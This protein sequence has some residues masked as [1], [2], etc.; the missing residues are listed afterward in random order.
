[1]DDQWTQGV[2]AA[3]IRASWARVGKDAGTR[4]DFGILASSAEGIDV[5]EFYAAYVAGLPSPDMDMTLPSAPPWVTFGV[6]AAASGPLV[7]VGVQHRWKGVDQASR[8]IWP[9]DFFICRYTDLA[10]HGVS[11][12]DLYGAIAR[13]DLERHDPSQV[14]LNIQPMR[15]EQLSFRNSDAESAAVIS[16]E[17]AAAIAAA[18]LD[19]P[20]AVTG[21]AGLEL[22]DRLRLLDAVAAL[23]PYGYRAGLSA[24]TA[25]SS[26]ILPLMRLV[27]TEF[28]SDGQHV[29]DLRRYAGPRAAAG[30]AYFRML[31]EKYENSGADRKY[32]NSGA[33]KIVRY[34]WQERHPET[35]S[36]NGRT[37][38]ALEILHRLDWE[39]D[40]IRRI[41]NAKVIEWGLAHEFFGQTEDFV[42]RWWPQLSEKHTLLVKSALESTRPETALLLVKHWYTIISA[43]IGLVNERLDQGDVEFAARSLAIAGSAHQ[44]DQAVV[45]ADGLLSRLIVPGSDGLVDLPWARRV[46]PR[47]ELLARHDVSKLGG[48]RETREFLRLHGPADGPAQI[49]QA[50]LLRQLATDKA[51]AKNWA[52][53]LC[54]SDRSDKNAAQRRSEWMTALDFSVHGS[55]DAASA[56]SACNTVSRTPGWTVPVVEL[57]RLF[58]NEAPV[59]TALVDEFLRQALAD[60]ADSG[61]GPVRQAVGNAI[62][63][64]FRPDPRHPEQHGVV[65]VPEG[66]LARV[67]AARLLLDL[68]PVDFPSRPDLTDFGQY[69]QGMNE[70]L[71]PLASYQR[72]RDEQL[73]ASLQANVIWADPSEPRPLSWGAIQLIKAWSHDQL[74]ARAL[75]EHINKSERDAVVA[76]LW[77]FQQLAPGEWDLLGESVPRLRKYGTRGHL[78]MAVQRAIENPDAAL[79]RVTDDST[80]NGQ[81]KV[82][83]LASDLE[84]AIFRAWLSEPKMEESLYIIQG[85]RGQDGRPYAG[86][87]LM[88]RVTPLRF[89]QVLSEIQSLIRNYRKA[90]PGETAVYSPGQLQA[91]KAAQAK[92]ADL[93]WWRC[94][95]LIGWGNVLGEDYGRLF[96]QMAEIRAQDGAEVYRRVVILLGA[97]RLRRRHAELL[98]ECTGMTIAELQKTQKRNRDY[99]AETEEALP[100]PA[101]R[102]A[103]GSGQPAGGPGETVAVPKRRRL[104]AGIS[105]IRRR[106]GRS[107]RRQDKESRQD[108]E[109]RQ[110]QESK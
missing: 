38:A 39:N 63:A 79:D 23:L 46:G 13:V 19:G 76:T 64:P 89:W 11:Y 97:K 80:E 59:L 68:P 57:S 32:E 47:I 108:Q 82:S 9:R 92:V 91:L 24:S 61:H 62:S 58:G 67:D 78:V 4:E 33:E 100:L 110:S 26:G 103:S 102:P 70:V 20:V 28:P 69:L 8:P 54:Y 50:L 107:A 51:S 86:Y 72:G 49:V 104:R 6:H 75:A 37:P 27:L 22:A 109:S 96:R 73:Q 71:H 48:Y 34:L 42:K 56:V 55:P 2:R 101:I 18:L 1:M 65:R 90:G 31:R 44:P 3:V 53:W 93:E 29:T 25:V 88:Q 77:R 106:L 30:A 7:S 74:R 81:D 52:S 21:T 105:G 45:R 12:A 5:R 16:F 43:I 17:S 41:R 36:Q 85:V 66:I 14:L 15:L 94:I 98:M 40:L 35:F 87:S 83:V 95:I 99:V 84:R 10:E 60:S